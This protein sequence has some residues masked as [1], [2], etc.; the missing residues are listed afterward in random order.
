MCTVELAR[1]LDLGLD[2]LRL[3]TW[4]GTASPDPGAR[5]LRRRALV[6]AVLAPALEQA[7]IADVWLPVRPVTRRRWPNGRITHDELKA[8]EGAGGA[9]ALPYLNPG[10]YVGAAQPMVQACGWRCPATAAHARGTGRA[11]PARRA[12]LQRECRPRDLDGHLQ[13]FGIRCRA[14]VSLRSNTG[15][16]WFPT[17]EFMDNVGHVIGGTDVEQF[18]DTTADG[19]Q[20]ALF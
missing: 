9:D 19:D 1:R 15:S 2:N 5:R 3:E 8:T 18:A 12:R 4:R 16:R 14:R 7:R 10:R 20:F 11:H 6:L 13:Q 17:G